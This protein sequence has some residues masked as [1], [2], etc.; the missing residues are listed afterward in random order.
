MDEDNPNPEDLL[1]KIMQEEGQL[2]KG[3]L[4]VFL[5]MAA[6]VGKTYAM[7]EAANKLQQ[8]GV[9]VVVGVVATHGRQETA[10]L[11]EGLEVIPEKTI[12]YKEATF[13]EFDIDTVLQRKPQ[14]VL[15]DE[16]AHSNVPGSRHLKRWQDVVEILDHGIDVYTTLNVQHIESLKDL[17]EG[18][19]GITIR[20]TVPDQVIDQAT[21]I[22]LID[23]TPY[24]LLRRL[25]E[26]KVYIPERSIIAAQHFF[27]ENRLMAL[28]EI[29]LRYAADKV[30]YDLKGL[31][32]TTVHT[33][34]WKPRERLLVAISHSPHSQKLIRTT[35]RLAFNLDAPWFAIH[36]D[37]G[38]ELSDEDR[39]SLDKNLTLVRDLGGELIMTSDS[40]IPQAIHRVARQKGITQIII[41]RAPPSL[42]GGFFG[43]NS[44]MNH[45][46]KECSEIDLHVI[47]QTITY[48]PK[49]GKWRLPIFTGQYISYL[50]ALFFVLGLALSNWLLLPIIG[51]RVTGG[52]FLLGLLAMSL[53]FRKGPVFLASILYALIWGFLFIPLVKGSK[54]LSEDIIILILYFITAVCTG[55]LTDRA[56][57]HSEILAKRER[58]TEVLY[59]IVHEIATLPTLEQVLASIKKRLSSVLDGQCDVIV[60]QANNGLPFNDFAIF[61]NEKELAAASWV[62]QNGKEAGWSTQTLP[63]CLNFYIPLKGSKE[64]L[65][66]L[67]YQPGLNRTLSL[68]EKSFLYTVGQQLASYL[69]K[70]F[71]EEKAHVQQQNKQVRKIYHSILDLIEN[72]FEGPLSTIQKSINDLEKEKSISGSSHQ[73][74]ELMQDAT[75]NLSHILGNISALVNLSSGLVPINRTKN[76][77][78]KL[79]KDC[80]EKIS[81]SR[82][83]YRWNV[84]IS[85]LLPDVLFDYDLIELLTCNM[86]FYTMELAT[87]DSIIQIELY[88]SGDFIA[89][90]VGG[91]SRVISKKVVDSIFDDSLSNEELSNLGMGLSLAK[92]IADRHGGQIKIQNKEME[93]SCFTFFLPC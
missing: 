6:G 16:L 24:E 9:D 8:E 64:V 13:E 29:V 52:V 41:G 36:V 90:S 86:I 31:T 40:N 87:E 55:I 30:D 73:S 33:D 91:G 47:R 22:E 63:M 4:K 45:L 42:F 49:L 89:L 38:S 77:M 92:V 5:G 20:E 68:D 25:K 66:I 10:R 54:P 35:R 19:T 14:V 57:R 61:K 65:G 76:S 85:E 43:R 72:L 83:G 21:Q 53:L 58:T 67:I 50:L 60:R 32:S 81:S 26:G 80:Y 79:V 75:G 39:S 3:K 44:L 37:D 69:E 56:R 48:K 84:K 15:V 1:K 82:K 70:V 7:L 62:F 88:Q 11:L 78:K 93:G 17:V 2:N 51:Y 27:Q 74:L 71:S 59:E 28:R 18:I 12:T 46:I 34:S 23:L